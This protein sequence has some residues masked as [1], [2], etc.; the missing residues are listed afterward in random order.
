MLIFRPANP[1]ILTKDQTKGVKRQFED[2]E[3]VETAFI[4][5]KIA[6]K[7]VEE[8]VIALTPDKAQ[9]LKQPINKSVKAKILQ[10]TIITSKG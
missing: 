6:K 3:D 7:S 10:Q 4:I 1:P 5:P 2:I 9:K 8:E